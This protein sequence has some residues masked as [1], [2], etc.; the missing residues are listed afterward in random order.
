M[1]SLPLLAALWVSGCDLFA[2][3]DTLLGRYPSPDQKLE[4]VVW[5]RNCGATTPY[6]VV[7]EIDRVRSRPALKINRDVIVLGQAGESLGGR[8]VWT[9]DRSV[10]VRT[11]LPLRDDA[12]RDMQ[13]R[14]RRRS[15]NV[16]IMQT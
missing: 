1:R 2:C 9:D 12:P 8:V 7:V 14:V 4:A 15:L 10:E 11:F 5:R 3:G 6:S 16:R 13:V